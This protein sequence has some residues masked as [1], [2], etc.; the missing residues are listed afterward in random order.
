MLHQHL[1][2]FKQKVLKTISPALTG[3]ELM[4]LTA[5]VCCSDHLCY[6]SSHL[7]KIL[8][9]MRWVGLQ[10]L[11]KVIAPLG[12]VL[13]CIAYKHRFQLPLRAAIIHLK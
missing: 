5:E 8:V 6:N 11:L 3:C 4:M 1:F 10:S 2:P 12:T 13:H 7:M 9:G